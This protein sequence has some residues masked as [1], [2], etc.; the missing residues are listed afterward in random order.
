METE[1]EWKE[2]SQPGSKES[3]ELGLLPG[4]EG[5]QGHGNP[6]EMSTGL[7]S[8]VSEHLHLK[9]FPSSMKSHFLW[10]PLLP[11]TTRLEYLQI[12]SYYIAM[13][14]DLTSFR[15]EDLEAGVNSTQ[16]RKGGASQKGS[17]TVGFES[18]LQDCL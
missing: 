17:L 16:A 3:Q 14:S 2:E 5:E 15:W 6:A 11:A 18:H 10:V 4:V 8:Q 1:R 12:L 9:P 13:A 7:G